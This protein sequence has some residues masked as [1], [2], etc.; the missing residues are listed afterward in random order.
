M[1]PR[2]RG[3]N[4]TFSVELCGGTHVQ[5]TGESRHRRR[6]GRRGRRRRAPPAA[7]TGARARP[8]SWRR[9]PPQERRLP[10]DPRSTSTKRLAPLTRIAPA[11]TPSSRRGPS[12]LAMAWREAGTPSGTCLASKLMPRGSGRDAD[13]KSPRMRQE[14]PRLRIVAIVARQRPARPHRGGVDRRSD[15]ESQRSPLVRP[16][17]KNTRGRVARPPR[18]AMPAPRRRPGEAALPWKRT[19]G[20][21]GVRS[22]GPSR[23][24]LHP[25]RSEREPEPQWTENAGLRSRNRVRPSDDAAFCG[26]QRK[27]NRL[28]SAPTG[29]MRTSGQRLS[30]PQRSG[31]TIICNERR[32]TIPDRLARPG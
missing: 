13:L 20:R 26:A 12:Q 18:H 6:V 10:Q 19:L 23:T 2:D 24:P 4:R 1:G 31:E 27:G 9:E 29:R 7:M 14:T 5:R 28:S 11:S 22:S 21:L 17:P 15:T 3:S 25:G 30:L 8:A 16:G 32:P